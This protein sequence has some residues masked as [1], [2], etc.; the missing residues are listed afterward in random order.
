MSDCPDQA[1]P[2]QLAP[3]LALATEFLRA[4]RPGD[5]IAPLREAARLQ[6]SNSAIQHDLGLACLEVGRLPDAVAALKRAVASNPLYADAY[7]RLG[8]AFEKLGNVREAIV[9]Y[10]PSSG[11]G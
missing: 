9:A 2:Q 1:A 8:I 11:P 3:L 7:F 10:D 4:G 6:P 5:A